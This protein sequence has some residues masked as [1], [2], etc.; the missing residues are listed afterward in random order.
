MVN[1][2]SG[3]ANSIVSVLAV[4][5]ALITGCSGNVTG[6]KSVPPTVGTIAANSATVNFTPTQIGSTATQNVTLSVSG[7]SVT[8]SSAHASGAGF[9]V[10]PLTLP[11]TLSPGQ[12]LVLAVQ[13]GPQTVGQLSSSL[14]IASNASNPT[15]T[16]ALSGSGTAAPAGTIAANSATVNFT[17]TQ[18]G[19]TATQNVTLS[20]S[21]ASVTVSSAHASGA[22]F[23]VVQPMLPATLSPGQSLVLAV[24]F[25]PQTVGQLSGSLLIASNASNPTLTIALSGSG[26]AAPAGTIAANSTIVNFGSTEVG[27]TATQNITL[28]VSG[29][30]VTVSSAHASGAG[31]TVV[32]P[33]LP[34]TLSPGQSLV[35]AVQFAPQT[36]GQ[37]SGS[38]VIA[39]NASNPTLTVT[40]SGSGIA[41]P[42]HSVTVSWESG[43]PAAVAYL[44]FRSDVSGGPYVPLTASVLS[45]MSYTD[46]TVS[47]GATYFY[48]VSELDAAGDQSA[49]SSEASATVP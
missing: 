12:S 4:S 18:I 34:A 40:L 19:S 26:T 47:S 22:G 33:M 29:A 44:V 9:T 42:A 20:V 37:L 30:S 43:N 8:V 27:S 10:A 49:F 5:A 38:L 32:Q 31:F 36:V 23:T 28:S 48:V 24:Q 17:P 15:L 46:T 21:G 16:I 39:S 11:A 1:R 3:R 25:A 2:R 45:E 7:A 41:A 13:F 6:S 35:L 14:V